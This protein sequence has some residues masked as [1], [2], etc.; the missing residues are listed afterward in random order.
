MGGLDRWVKKHVTGPI[1]EKVIKPA[2]KAAKDLED[3]VEKKIKQNVEGAK[4]IGRDINRAAND[5]EDGVEHLVKESVEELE[6]ARDAVGDFIENTA[7]YVTDHPFETVL[8]IGGAFAGY[9]VFMDPVGKPSL[10]VSLI[11]PKGASAVLITV[12]ATTDSEKDEQ[13]PGG[14]Q[15]SLPPPVV[16]TRYVKKDEIEMD[17]LQPGSTVFPSGPGV[18]MPDIEFAF[19]TESGE[20]R[21]DKKGGALAKRSP[22]PRYKGKYYRRHGGFDF[23]AEPGENIRAPLT[24][25]IVRPSYPYGTSARMPNGD[26]VLG[27]EIVTDNGYSS[28]IWYVKPN[29]E[30][31]AALEAKKKV[32]IS[33]GRDT[34]G[35]AQD[36]EG[37]YKAKGSSSTVPPHVHVEWRDYDNRLINPDGSLYI[38]GSKKDLNP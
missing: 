34:I 29:E 21:K 33:A 19:P 31:L 2:S 4:E 8:I 16:K 13:K 12:A 26:P 22:P 5:V 23:I 11:G 38:E 25:Y 17:D 10:V 24:G 32:P 20:L 6:K 14:T 9:A 37:Y 28:K 15:E 18:P 27:L 30:I 36:I 35:V 7:D 1:K 3:S